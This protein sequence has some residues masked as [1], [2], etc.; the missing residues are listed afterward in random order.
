MPY[1][2][3][4]VIP[5][6]VAISTLTGDFTVEDVRDFVQLAF[7]DFLL[8]GE[9]KVHFI[10]DFGGMRKFPTQLLQVH[11]MTKPFLDHPNLGV[12]VMI[13]TDNP[14]L[15]FVTKTVSQMLGVETYVESDTDAALERIKRLD[16][17]LEA[18]E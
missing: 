11:E 13:S 18:K 12:F 5:G 14:M 1:T 17:H 15:K 4:W 9:G 8:Q 2:I 10:G 6:H 3:E 7:N 16:A